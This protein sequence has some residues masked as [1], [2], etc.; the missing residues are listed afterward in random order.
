MRKF[1]IAL[2]LFL[3]IQ[4]FPVKGQEQ[5]RIYGFVKDQL[6]GEKLIGANISEQGTTNGTSADY[7]GYFSLLVKN[8]SIL[9]VSFLGYKNFVGSFILKKDTLVNILLVSSAEQL[10]EIVV[11]VVNYPQ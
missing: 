6:T 8:P 7:N 3:I 5:F 10:D 11:M 4:A 9:Q 2:C 1:L